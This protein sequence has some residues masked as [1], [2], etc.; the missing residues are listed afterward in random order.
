[1]NEK[2][3][4]LLVISFICSTQTA[5]TCPEVN[6]VAN[7]DLEKVSFFSED[8]FYFEIMMINFVNQKNIHRRLLLMMLIN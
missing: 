3:I 7:F 4:I 2:M 1:M 5:N 6:A 8:N